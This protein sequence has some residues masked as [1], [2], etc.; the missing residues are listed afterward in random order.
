MSVVL[1]TG[2]STG[3]GRELARVS[4]EAGDR[5]YATMRDPSKAGDLEELAGLTVL[6]LDV[7][8]DAS[9]A[10]A[11]DEVLRRAGRIDV[12]VNNAGIDTLG[13]I[14]DIA[15]DR[16]REIMETNFFGALRVTRRALPAMRAQGAGTIVM[17]TSVAAVGSS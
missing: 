12:V 16:I 11:V 1:I 9:V 4:A 5:V 8:D 2:C 14:E 17:V 6:A 13:A 3:I 7:T 15:I 10:K